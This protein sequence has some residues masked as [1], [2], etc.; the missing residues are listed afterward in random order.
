MGGLRKNGGWQTFNNPSFRNQ[1]QGIQFVN[2]VHPVREH[3]QASPL[4]EP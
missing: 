4:A 1:G 3:G 2:P